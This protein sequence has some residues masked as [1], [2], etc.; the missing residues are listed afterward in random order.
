[1]KECYLSYLL[2]LKEDVQKIM[3]LMKRD[4]KSLLDL[5]EGLRVYWYYDLEDKRN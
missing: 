4:I 1:M 2:Y 5:Q 3:G